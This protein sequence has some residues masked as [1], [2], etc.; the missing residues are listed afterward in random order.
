[1]G[2]NL[3]IT[4]GTINVRDDEL[5]GNTLSIYSPTQADTA[6]INLSHGAVVSLNAPAS[7]SSVFTVNVKGADTLHLAT[8]FPSGAGATIN[9]ADHAT[10]TAD[11]NMAFG[12]AVIIGGTHSHLVNDRTNSLSGTDL[13]I[14]TDVQGKGS[15]AVSGA[16]SVRGQLEFGGS[17]SRGQ[18]VSVSG[19]PRRLVPAFVKID[20][21]GEF[22]GSTSIGVFGEIDLAGLA[23]ADSYSLKNDLLSIYSGCKVIDTLRLSALPPP[24]SLP[25]HAIT[26]A[27]TATGIVIDRGYSGGGTLL[28]IHV[29]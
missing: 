21:P 14:N 10:L 4:A 27:Q 24:S 11:F 12:G 13:I 8:T 20:Q 17:V 22:K 7:K 28:P 19:D 16:Q 15:Y 26:V 18:S 5:A 29:S 25:D 23:N 2:D 1:M 6:T 3:T 9:L